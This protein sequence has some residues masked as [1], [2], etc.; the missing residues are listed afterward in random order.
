MLVVHTTVVAIGIDVDAITVH[1]NSLLR[2]SLP[3]PRQQ[4]NALGRHAHFY[5][6]TVRRL[7]IVSSAEECNDLIILTRGNNDDQ[8]CCN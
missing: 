5:E 2:F 4:S 1:V 3:L 7:Y 8:L 6:S